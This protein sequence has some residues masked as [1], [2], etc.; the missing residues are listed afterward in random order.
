MASL[1]SSYAL[2]S[3]AVEYGDSPS[4]TA[5][6]LGDYLQCRDYLSSYCRIGYV[7]QDSHTVPEKKTVYGGI[8]RNV[9]KNT[10]H[11]EYVHA[12][13][14]EHDFA[15]RR[16]MDL[17]AVYSAF[18]PAV[19]DDD[20]ALL[21]MPRHHW[22]GSVQAFELQLAL[23][24]YLCPEDMVLKDSLIGSH[25]VPLTI[26]ARSGLMMLCDIS[27]DTV[28]SLSD[29][30]CKS[31]MAA[32]F[33]HLSAAREALVESLSRHEL[34]S[35]HSDTRQWLTSRISLTLVLRNCEPAQLALRLKEQLSSA[36]TRCEQLQAEL[37][38]LDAMAHADS[39]PAPDCAVLNSDRIAQPETADS[40]DSAETSGAR[41]QSASSSSTDVTART[42]SAPASATSTSG[43]ATS[44]FGSDSGS[45]STA[46]SFSTGTVSG[47]VLTKSAFGSATDADSSS[48]SSSAAAAASSASAF[49][50]ANS[51]TRQRRQA[52][53]QEYEH[54]SDSLSFAQRCLEILRNLSTDNMCLVAMDAVTLAQYSTL[55]GRE[56]LVKVRLP[57]E[58]VSAS[59]FNPG[60]V[61]AELA[62]CKYSRVQ[63][64]LYSSGA[65][66]AST[67]PLHPMQQ[68]P[69]RSTHMQQ[70]ICRPC[71]PCIS[72]TNNTASGILLPLKP[73]Y[74]P[75]QALLPRAPLLAPLPLPR[76]G[77][78]TSTARRQVRP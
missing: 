62:A 15:L 22:W 33:D 58:Q 36:Q 38:R 32:L 55:M 67:R 45:V 44:A 63:T 19:H 1:E 16:Q 70:R 14:E 37:A 43:S 54:A 27:S 13:P 30:H 77:D 35:S 40:A 25:H 20:L 39:E 71:I 10:A 50:S 46:S 61:T 65:A 78:K 17:A 5:A 4:F 42:A 31:N 68:N 23:G 51:S 64:S 75:H 26:M 34:I 56:P 76:A 47:L 57:E 60:S 6:L 59:W 18:K 28:D 69:N 3:A 66:H 72:C 29:P 21:A 24:R 8:T 11:K 52:L 73:Q 2:N 7:A 12:R 48:V 41:T 9:L 53:Q 49:A 74:R